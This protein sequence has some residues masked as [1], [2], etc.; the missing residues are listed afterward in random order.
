MGDPWDRYTMSA[1]GI[2][3]S[4]AGNPKR[5]A[6]II[7]P[8]IPS[9]LPMG[10]SA[11]AIKDRR[12]SPSIL[13]YPS[14]QSTMPAGA[15][16]TTARPSTKRVRSSNERMSTSPTFGFRNGG[17]SSTKDEGIP[18][19]MV[20]D[21]IFALRSVITTPSTIN[22]VS[23]MADKILPTTP[24]VK[25]KNMLMSKINVGKRPLQGIITLVRMAIKRSL[26]L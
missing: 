5:N 17:N 9:A 15:A 8:S 24:E 2:T 13:Q 21:N 6:S 10:S 1:M 3:I 14:S 18:L 19:R 7:T 16:T 26:G 4:L 22:P 23:K 20:L 25:T 12:V 11:V